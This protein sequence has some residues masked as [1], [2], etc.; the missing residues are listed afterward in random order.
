MKTPIVVMEN[1]R[2]WKAA[3]PAV[4]VVAA[5]DYL[6]QSQYLKERDLKVVNLCRS[7]TYLTQGYYTSLLAQA[8]RHR[9]IPTVRT[10]NDLR[11]KAIYSLEVEDLDA[12]IQKSLKSRPGAAGSDRF[13]LFIFFGQC[14]GN[15]LQE[16]ARQIFDLFQCPLLRVEFRYQGKWD[17]ASIRYAHLHQLTPEQE[18]LFIEAFQ[19]HMARRW[20]RP[21]TKNQTRYDLAVLYNPAEALPPSNRRALQKFV[22]VGEKMGIGV[23]LIERKDYAK[24]AEYDGLFIRETTQIEHHTFRFAKK[25]EY[26]GLVVIDDPDSIMKC[27]N[28]VYLDELL[29]TH[30]IAT[31]R[32][33]VLQGVAL[34]T[35]RALEA[36]RDAALRLTQNPARPQDPSAQLAYVVCFAEPVIYV[37]DDHGDHCTRSRAH[38]SHL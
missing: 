11:S 8:R 12:V 18:A 23:D 6:G 38:P 15:G 36:E 22:R 5:R 32:T 21:R 3:Y 13:E 28:K 7:Y 34:K 4:E 25:A 2:E 26:E 14:G 20:K 10:I 30:R 27:T 9:V 33:R 16:L 29:K 19:N 1:P 31:P 37:V 35:L 17:L 24:L